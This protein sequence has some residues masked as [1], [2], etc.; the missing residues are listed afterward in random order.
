MK[1]SILNTVLIAVTFAAIL[2]AA[3]D[4][5]PTATAATAATAQAGRVFTMEKTVVAAKRLPADLA[6]ADPD[7]A[8]VASNER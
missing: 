8:S 4:P 7:V 6:M 1:D 3:T 5:R 2:F